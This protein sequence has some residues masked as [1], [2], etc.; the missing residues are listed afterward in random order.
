MEKALDVVYVLGSGSN[1]HNT[2]IRFSL[3]SIEQNLQNVGKV[4]VVGECPS[5]LQNVIHIKAPDIFDPAINADGNIITKVLAACKD[6]RLSDDFLFINDDHLVLQTINIENVPPIHKGD[7]STFKANYFDNNFWR[8]RLKR[9]MQVLQKKGYSCLH[10][11]CHTPILFNKYKFPEIVNTFDYKTDIG[12]TMK[13]LY[14]NVMYPD[15]EF[16]MDQKRTVFKH[17]IL[18]QLNERLA[19]PTFM[20]FNDKG[21]NDSLKWWLIDKFRSK[22]SYEK[23]CP[24]DFIFDLFF[25]TLNGKPFDDGVQLFCKH[26][27]NRYKNLQAMFRFGETK[28]LRSKLNYKLSR[29]I[30]EL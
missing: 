2:E 24:E 13:S 17:Y 12:Y 7:M 28:A 3:R 15:G 19:I 23:D 11:D 9:T 8:G 1:W 18:E 29:R 30:N 6:K 26:F 5:F 25:W 16:F 22:S 21:L 10:F 27:K 14:G 4:F 20:S